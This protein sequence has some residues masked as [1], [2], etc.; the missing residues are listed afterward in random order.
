[1]YFRIDHVKWEGKTISI[2]KDVTIT[3]PYTENDIQLR[4]GGNTQTK[5]HIIKIVS[6]LHCYIFGSWFSWFYLFI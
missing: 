2:L 3:E 1:M 5:E 4:Q 6:I